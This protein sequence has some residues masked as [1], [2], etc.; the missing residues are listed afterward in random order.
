MSKRY[1]GGGISFEQK[2]VYQEFSED[3]TPSPGGSSSLSGLT[4]VDISN[5]SDGQTIVYNAT[6]G[7]WVNG[8]SGGI[9]YATVIFYNVN[10]D[11]ETPYLLVPMPGVIVNGIMNGSAQVTPTNNA[12]VKVPLGENGCFINF[13]FLDSWDESFEPVITGDVSVDLVDFG[14]IITGDGTISLKS[15]VD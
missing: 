10:E 6:S 12:V 9:Q 15:G 13:G 3:D 7:K 5:P 2:D 11:E 14:F 8:E 1:L 4:D